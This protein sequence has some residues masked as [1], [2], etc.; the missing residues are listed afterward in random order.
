MGFAPFWREILTGLKNHTFWLCFYK[1]QKWA[2]RSCCSF[3]KI[4]IALVALVALYKKSEKSDLL[5]LKERKRDSLFFVKKKQGIRTKKPKIE[6]PTLQN[7]DIKRI[8]KPNEFLVENKLLKHWNIYI[9]Q[10]KFNVHQCFD[11][12]FFKNWK[13]LQDWFSRRDGI[14]WLMQM[15]KKP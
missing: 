13:D 4:V 9:F 10:I 11:V 3:K 2:N 8:A 12:R 14:D 5:F 7:T 15:G 6:F 1:K